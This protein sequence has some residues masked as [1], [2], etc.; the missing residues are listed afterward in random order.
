MAASV[1]RVMLFG[2]FPIVFASRV[3]LSML[4]YYAGFFVPLALC[5]LSLR[6]RTE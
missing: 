4:L 2:A 6:L 1:A 5:A 3:P